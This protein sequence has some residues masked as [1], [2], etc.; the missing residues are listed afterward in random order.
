M[1]EVIETGI[2][3]HIRTGELISGAPPDFI[4]EED[5]LIGHSTDPDEI[6]HIRQRKLS[7][8]P[9]SSYFLVRTMSTRQAGKKSNHGLNY[10]MGIDRF[11]LENGMEVTDARRVR[12]A[13]Y[14]VYPGITHMQRGIKQALLIDRTLKNC[15]G[16]KRRFHDELDMDTL[17]AAFSYIPQS[18][19]GRVT[20]LGIEGV[21]HNVPQV[22]I[23]AN[24]HDSLA[25]QG[26]FSSA[27][28][29]TAAI[30][31]IDEQ[32]QIPLE[33]HNRKFML[34]R[35]FKVGL[36]WGESGMVKI[37]HL[38]PE[39]IEGAWHALSEMQ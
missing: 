20:N 23:S 26:I 36:N 35:E 29:L 2:D 14:D 19:V 18:T 39:H 7:H 33:Y 10:G 11:A 13:Y 21:Y 22:T 5:A 12:L 15:L 30:R 8:W 31:A 17:M 24:V 1:I 38:T 16:E 27:S 32:F 9:L 34:K 28:D 25:S 3:P 4:R 37:K 6:A